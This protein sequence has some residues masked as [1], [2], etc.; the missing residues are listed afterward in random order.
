MR[1]RRTALFLSDESHA[2]VPP[3]S[4]VPESGGSS[5]PRMFRRVLL[6]DP[7]GPVTATVSPRPTSRSIPLR[8]ESTDPPS[9]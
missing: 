2:S 8:I 9:P 6:P 7:L 4:T 5:M 1:F 3:I